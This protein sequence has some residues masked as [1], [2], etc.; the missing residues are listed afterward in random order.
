M[1]W[2]KGMGEG[3]ILFLCG[4]IYEVGV[5]LFFQKFKVLR[6]HQEGGFVGAV[7]NRAFLSFSG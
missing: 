5:D 6:V 4:S 3:L 2:V 7:V 1:L